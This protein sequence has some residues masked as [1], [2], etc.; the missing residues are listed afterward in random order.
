MTK[1]SEQREFDMRPNKR[2]EGSDFNNPVFIWPNVST[3]QFKTF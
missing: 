2:V 1:L 3:A